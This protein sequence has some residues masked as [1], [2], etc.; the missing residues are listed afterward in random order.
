MAPY[1]VT[2]ELSLAGDAPSQSGVDRLLDRLRDAAPG[3]EPAI[4]LGI[5]RLFVGLTIMAA[6]PDAARHAAAAALATVFARR[7]SH[8]RIDGP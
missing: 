1:R 4:D 5:G 3:G 7:P 8:V 6:E 2:M